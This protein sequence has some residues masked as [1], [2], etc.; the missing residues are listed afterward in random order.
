MV[1]ATA[2]IGALLAE[3]LLRR[4]FLVGAVLLSTF[5]VVMGLTSDST[6]WKASYCVAGALGI[7]ASFI[8]MRRNWPLQWLGSISIVLINVILLV[9]HGRLSGDL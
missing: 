3:G 8:V 1:T 4:E 2:Q 6:A 7:V 5:T 9:V